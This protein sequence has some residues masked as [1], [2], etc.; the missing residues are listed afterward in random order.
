MTGAENE[1]ARYAFEAKEA[2]DGGQG[3]GTIRGGGTRQRLTLGQ[4]GQ[5]VPSQ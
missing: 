1:A 4:R 5:T 2:K 3:P